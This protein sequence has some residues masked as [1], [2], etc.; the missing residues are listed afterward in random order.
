MA[1]MKNDKN[2]KNEK[3]KIDKWVKRGAIVGGLW[4]FVVGALYLIVILVNRIGGLSA[5]GKDIGTLFEGVSI[6]W[7]IFWLPLYLTD[8]FFSLL[9]SILTKLAYTP[10]YLLYL[11]LWIAVPTFFGIL[12]GIFMIVVVKKVMK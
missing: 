12:I 9:A 5:H 4:G 2:V 1:K 6:I 3:R 11:L 7:K 8:T 10:L